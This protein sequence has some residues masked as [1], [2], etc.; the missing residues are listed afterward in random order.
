MIARAREN[1]KHRCCP[2]GWL[3]A[4]VKPPPEQPWLTISWPSQLE[5]EIGSDHIA[6]MAKIASRMRGRMIEGKWEK[7]GKS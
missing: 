7:E 6:A 1:G 5:I 2:S 4:P 3:V